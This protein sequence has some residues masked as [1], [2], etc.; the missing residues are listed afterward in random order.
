MSVYL[1]IADRRVGFESRFRLFLVVKRDQ[2][3]GNAMDRLTF[4]SRGFLRGAALAFMVATVPMAI[5]AY[6]AEGDR[7]VVDEGA[8]DANFAVA[9]AAI[10]AALRLGDTDAVATYADEAILLDFG[11]GSGRD[12]F[13]NR[14]K[15]GVK[16]GL[17][18][19][20]YRAALEEA[21][22]F[23]GR[24]TAPD[25]FEAPFTFT[26]PLPEDLDAFDANFVLGSDVPVHAAPSENSEIVGTVSFEL[27]RYN[28]TAEGNDAFMPIRSD[29]GRV[30]GFVAVE[31]LKSPLDHR[32][33]FEKKDGRWVMTAFV[34]GD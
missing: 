24:F 25:I 28:E 22:M 26:E 12:G 23:G 10:V 9:R 2:E 18:G 31:H 1:S 11:G 16:N 21:L 15:S 29:D 5:P 17:T 30:S 4:G 7:P 3:K 33:I 8:A 14:L 19:D 32:A 34:A 20:E 13:A 6:A 27:V